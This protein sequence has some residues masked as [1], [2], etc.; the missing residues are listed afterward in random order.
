MIKVNFDNKH[1]LAEFEALADEGKYIE[2]KYKHIAF[3]C[4]GSLVVGQYYDNV[5]EVFG[6]ICLFD[7]LKDRINT[8]TEY[9]PD[10]FIQFSES[11]SGINVKIKAMFYFI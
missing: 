5:L 11:I 2:N 9:M 8:L 1:L 7:E 3:Y 4:N 6:P 10:T